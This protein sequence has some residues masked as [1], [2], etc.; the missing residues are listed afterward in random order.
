MDISMN[1]STSS[2]RES[3]ERRW[4]STLSRTLVLFAGILL[5]SV[6]LILYWLACSRRA[7]RCRSRFERSNSGSMSYG[8]TSAVERAS[9]GPLRRSPPEP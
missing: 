9:R 2:V 5:V 6:A 1:A 7:I 3:D 8:V 4:Q